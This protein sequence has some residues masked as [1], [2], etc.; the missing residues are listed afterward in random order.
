MRPSTPRLSIGAK[1][2]LRYT[3]ALAITVSVVAAF[4]Y[5]Q[6]A[7]RINRDALLLIEMQTEDLA[8][9]YASQRAQHAPDEVLAWMRGHAERVVERADPSLRLGVA[10]FSASGDSVLAAGSLAREGAPLS[11]ALLQGKVES[12][13]RAVN[14]GEEYAFLSMAIRVPDGFLQVAVNTQRYAENVAHIRD[15]F[16]LSLPLVLLLTALGGWM[17]ARGSLRPIA[18]IT[19]SAQRITGANLD[20]SV[21][22]TGSG[23]ELDQLATTLNDMLGRIREGLERMRRFNAD[24]AHELRTPLTAISSQIEV[25]LEKERDPDEYRTVL[26]GVLER[27]QALA[28][29]VDAMLRLARTEAGL[30]AEHRVPTP[31]RPVLETVVEFF[32]PLAEDGG[33]DLRMGPIPDATV[34][35]DVSWLHQLFSNLVSNAIKF[36]PAGGAVSVESEVD[37]ESIRVYVRDTG[38]GIPAES[39]SLVFERFHRLRHDRAGF[40]LGLPI[41]QEI[42]RAHGGRIEVASAEGAGA[43]F[44]VCLPLGHGDREES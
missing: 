35:G 9:T 7:H 20:E 27:V 18:H 17:L 37:A 24:A 26:A 10:L 14:L 1:L 40:G 3:A 15:V 30:D 6:V 42:A 19:Q 2:A 28:Q 34:I 44:S 16:L 11:R 29:G 25:T 23:D 5:A 4:V 31:L 39:L 36:T 41:A 33:L 32:A 13:V 8:E 38:P 12:Q 22:V 43:L 21:P